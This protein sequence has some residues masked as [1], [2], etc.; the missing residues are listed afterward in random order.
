MNIEEKAQIEFENSEMSESDQYKNAKKVF[1]KRKSIFN[2]QITKT[3]SF[4]D[5]VA[6][7]IR[8]KALKRKI[9]TQS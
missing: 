5:V 6:S 1:Q 4:F 7:L 9:K 2:R 8:N 3:I